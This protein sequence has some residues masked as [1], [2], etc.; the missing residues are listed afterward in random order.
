MTM[1]CLLTLS[2]IKN[3]SG[4]VVD[5]EVKSKPFF[6]SFG[7]AIDS[8]KIKPNGFLYSDST[9]KKREPRWTKEKPI[10]EFSQIPNKFMVRCNDS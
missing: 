6:I 9:Y 7:V 8:R 3:N 10:L 4:Q 5:F 1:G 2:S